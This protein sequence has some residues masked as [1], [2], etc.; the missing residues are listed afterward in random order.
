MSDY[1]DSGFDSFLSR[2]IDDLPQS[3]LDSTGPV[4][5]QVRY[6][7]TQV[8][9]ALGDTLRIGSIYFDGVNGRISIY[10]QNNEVVRIGDLGD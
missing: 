6:D 1:T 3:N 4:T 5:N 10:D 7:S 8:S 9:G 2:S